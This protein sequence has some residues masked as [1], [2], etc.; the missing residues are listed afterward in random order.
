[1]SEKATL[2]KLLP[3]EPSS[4]YGNVNIEELNARVMAVE[5]A[6]KHPALT[7]EQK[8]ASGQFE[9]AARALGELHVYFE[10]MPPAL[11][12]AVAHHNRLAT[13]LEL[14]RSLGYTSSV[15]IVLAHWK[16]TR[17]LHDSEVE[18]PYLFYDTTHETHVP[19]LLFETLSY[20]DWSSGSLTV[21][22][23]MAFVS[24]LEETFKR[25]HLY[26]IPRIRRKTARMASFKILGD[27]LSKKKTLLSVCETW[28]EIDAQLS[29][30]IFW[31]CGSL[32]GLVMGLSAAGLVPYPA[33]DFFGSFSDETYV[34]RTGKTNKV[35]YLAG[36]LTRSASK[37]MQ[38]MKALVADC[39]LLES[40]MGEYGHNVGDE[41]SLKAILPYLIVHPVFTVEDIAGWATLSLSQS[42]RICN[43]LV[44]AGIIANVSDKQRYKRYRTHKFTFERVLSESGS[45]FFG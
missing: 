35:L 23:Y 16:A 22:Q 40:R 7:A 9:R 1:M 8:L 39:A 43:Q 41:S 2:S 11:R 6:Q 36:C 18:D 38:L 3:S 34:N 24:E 45:L 42:R 25:A 30:H 33:L 31:R 27:V 4:F 26:E 44:H 17:K 13:S 10:L 15:D 28:V 29:N 20:F 32:F 5:M 14:G 19:P 12:T 37:S 21:G